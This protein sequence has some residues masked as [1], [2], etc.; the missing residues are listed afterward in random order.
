MRKPTHFE[1]LR[2]IHN[3]W[4]EGKINVTEVMDILTSVYKLNLTSLTNGGLTAES[5]DKKTK[6]KLQ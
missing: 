3:L 5:E 2:V 6:Y 4:V 1:S